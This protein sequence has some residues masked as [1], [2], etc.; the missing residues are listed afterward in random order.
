L[1]KQKTNDWFLLDFI[2][3]V[4]GKLKLNFFN[5][6]HLKNH[7]KSINDLKK[8]PKK[9]KLNPKSKINLNLDLFFHEL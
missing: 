3:L 1:K 2:A 6:K 4:T 8:P 7:D 5:P 9:N